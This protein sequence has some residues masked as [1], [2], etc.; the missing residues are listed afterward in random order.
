MNE[1]VTFDP[2]D[3]R[4]ITDT[5]ETTRFEDTY[6]IQRVTFDPLDPRSITDTQKRPRVSKIHT[7]YAKRHKRGY[8]IETKHMERQPHRQ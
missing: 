6:K 3:P 7:K 2:L 1:R 8:K 5:K 4:S